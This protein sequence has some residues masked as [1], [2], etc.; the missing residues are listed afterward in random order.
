MSDQ[1]F[2]LGNAPRF[3]AYINPKDYDPERLSLRECSAAVERSQV[4]LRGWYF[5]HIDRRRGILV[6]E[7]GA[8]VFQTTEPGRWSDHAEEWRL[9]RSGQF[10]F[11]G[12]VW[13]HANAD[14]QK[15]ARESA[16]YWDVRRD[17]ADIP[18]F[19]EFRM[20]IA[21]VTEAY[22]FAA[23]LAQAA[24][25]DSSLT[26]DVGFRGV[27]GYGLASGDFGVD[28]YDAYPVQFDNPH[29]ATDIA[30]DDIIGNPRGL[31]RSAILRL[32]E[33]F[34]WLDAAPQMIEQ[35]QNNLLGIG[36]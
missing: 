3:V 21:Q 34:G 15:R 2:D 32:F 11:K 6:G 24:R 22:I 30:I 8:Y 26:I 17:P 27:R 18:G 29:F 19:L 4:Q 28:L 7:G 13:E 20:F 9:Y 12:M 10:M 16:R 25:Y 33:Q 35:Q 23:R 31:A 36:K 5:P 1:H 14:F